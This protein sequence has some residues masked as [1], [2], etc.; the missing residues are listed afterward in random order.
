MSN[1]QQIIRQLFGKESLKE[2]PVETLENF[3]RENPLFGPAQFLLAR[4]YKDTGNELFEKQIQ[5][6]ALYFHDPLWLHYQLS[7]V[8]QEEISDFSIHQHSVAASP[9]WEPTAVNHDLIEEVVIHQE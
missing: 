9:A 4:K 7:D 8:G 3:T 5:K 1:V 6:T 2:I